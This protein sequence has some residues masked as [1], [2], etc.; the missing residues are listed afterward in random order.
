MMKVE[1]PEG[2]EWEKKQLLN[3]VIVSAVARVVPLRRNVDLWRRSWRFA[4]HP[5]KH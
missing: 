1:Q 4:F 3:Y 5:Q 2:K